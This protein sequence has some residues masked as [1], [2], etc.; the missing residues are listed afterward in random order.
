MTWLRRLAA[1]F[2]AVVVCL[3]TVAAQPV[4]ERARIGR[5]EDFDAF[6]RFVGDAYAYFDGK[7]TDWPA[8]CAAYRPEAAA[9]DGR[10][11]FIGVVER[12]LAELYDA[13]A[14]LGTSTPKSPRLV[15]TD[16][17]VYAE[18]RDDRAT[19]V[20]VRAASGARTAGVRS[21]MR[22]IEIDGR[23]VDD[24]VAAVMP[25]HLIAPDPKARDWALRTALAGLQDREPVS[26][27][28]DDRGTRRTFAFVPGRTRPDAALSVRRAGDVG[29]VTI[30]NAL[31]DAKLI[32]AFDEALD[33]LHDAKA[34]VLDLR[35]T[36]SGGNTTV[37]R[38]IMG[39]L[40]AREAAYQRHERISEA[41]ETG[42]RHVW[43]EYV[44]PR[45]A[46][47]SGPVAVL[48]GRWTGSMGEGIAIGL[49]AARGATVIGSPMA[50]LLGSLDE[51]R[52][53]HAGLTVRVPAEKLFHVDGTPR[54]AFV[55]CPVTGD[56]DDDSAALGQ[57]IA[58]V[59]R[60]RSAQ[61]GCRSPAM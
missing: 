47:F 42:I 13:H 5:L 57:A 30:H 15:P 10:G 23:M 24:A 14:H 4:D 6:C 51:R 22:V 18:W 25:K 50:G 59:S 19:I 11:A 27:V 2:G 53:P 52:L 37:A 40:V 44:E 56:A 1:G 43:L 32:A 55:P 7:R 60:P 29:I 12:A 41:R 26:L 61:A 17:D 36:P 58:M 34:L 31:G 33:A 16:T 54:E 3:A 39:R 8:V 46:T 9:A 38:G 45:G 20:E 28:V 49:Q 48:V 21:G 35:D